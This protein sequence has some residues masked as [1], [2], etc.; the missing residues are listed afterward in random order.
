MMDIFI[1]YRR[2]DSAASTGRLYDHLIRHF[3]KKRVFR[4]IEGIECGTDFPEKIA[5]VLHSAKVM[6][7]LIGPLWLNCTDTNGGRC[8][9]NDN[10]WICKEIAVALNRNIAILPLLVAD[11]IM[12]KADELPTQIKRLADKQ[13]REI[14][15]QSWDYDVGQIIKTL[16]RL[17]PGFNTRVKK[18]SILFL[19][20]CVTLSVFFLKWY[21]N[22]FNYDDLTRTLKSI[23][24]TEINTIEPEKA[25]RLFHNNNITT[26]V[27]LKHLI[28]NTIIISKLKKIYYDE[29]KREQLDIIAIADYAPYLIIHNYSSESEEFIRDKVIKSDEL[30]YSYLIDT[31]KSIGVSEIHLA[32]EDERILSTFKQSGIKTKSQLKY[33]IQDSHAIAKLKEIYYDELGRGIDGVAIAMYATYLHD[34]KVSRASEDDIRRTIHTSDEWLGRRTVAIPIGGFP[35]GTV[36]K[37]DGPTF[38]LIQNGSKLPIPDR[39]THEF[40]GYPKSIRV[41]EPDLKTIP[42]GTPLRR[43]RKNDNGVWMPQ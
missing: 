6:L 12:P 30:D 3:P 22:D 27:Q 15:E 39:D 43:M 21:N 33:L 7:V 36:I 42:T 28:D 20:A 25:L 8:L 14:R 38:Y 23:G 18:T 19:F 13:A 40:M 29:L 11:A 1:C 9:D 10:D 17:V 41:K 24:I 4:D 35:N 2:V 5:N 31:L 34:R 16:Y 37:G 26:K 32:K